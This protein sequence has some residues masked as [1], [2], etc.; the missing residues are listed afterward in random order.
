M[1]RSTSTTPVVPVQTLKHSEQ[2]RVFQIP[3][4]IASN[5]KEFTFEIVE[6]DSYGEITSR[7]AGENQFITQKVNEIGIEMVVVPGGTFVMG[8][9]ES[10]GKGC[11][12]ERPQH[13][14]TVQAILMSKYPITFSQWKAVASLQLVHRKLKP[15]PSPRNWGAKRPV[16]EVSWHDAI[17]FCDR[18]SRETGH[19]Y[20][21]PT[22]AEWEYACRAGTT[23]PF[24]FGATI[25]S[26]LANYDGTYIYHSEP[27]GENRAKHYRLE[28]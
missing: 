24:H 11:K 4:L 27:K 28:N 9:P 20:R 18:L 13:P 25:T 7:H 14:V 23:T 22:E 1:E 12:N 6:V 17:E 3:E 16:V 5:L 10:E 2:K 19:T 21:L 15:R 8:S 26:G